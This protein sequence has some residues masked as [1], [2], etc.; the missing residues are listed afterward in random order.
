[1]GDAMAASYDIVGF[2]L[3]GTLADSSGDLVASI[4]HA[5]TRL[6]RP[7]L[8]SAQV[9]QM[10]GT[11]SRRLVEQ[12]L[13]ATG[14]AES[15]Q[16]D[17]A[18]AIYLD[19][20]ARHLTDHTRLYPGVTAA[21]ETLRAQG[22]TLAVVTNKLER[23]A[24]DLLAALGISHHFGTII[25]GDTMGPGNNKPSALPIQEMIA[26]C[27]GGKA[28]F[29]GDSIFDT[30]AARN[31]GIPCIVVRFGFHALSFEEV[32]FDEMGGDATID[33]FD[34]LLPTL[35]RLAQTGR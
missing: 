20:Y 32:A 9:L 3:D 4:N 18:L 30:H 10:V 2:D 26:R 22:A 8:P 16:V 1:M 11:G 25:G 35:E 7:A 34:E 27:G 23:L 14:T 5:L 17:D 33:H 15:V 21:L 19:Y 28:A 13:H 31:A 12:A 29:V 6:G 24:V